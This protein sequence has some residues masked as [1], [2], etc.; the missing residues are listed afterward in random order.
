MTKGQFK[1]VLKLAF[2][3]FSVLLSGCEAEKKNAQQ[4]KIKVKRFSMKDV[5]MQTNFKLNNAVNEIKRF[6][7]NIN[8]GS[9]KL[10]FDDKSGLYFDDEKGLYIE[11]D[12]LKSYTFPIIRTSSDEK[13]KNICFN[14]KENGNYDVYLVKYDFTMQQ[15]LTL[16]EE[17]KAA[18][19]K[20]FISLMKDGVKLEE[21]KLQCIDIYVTTTTEYVVPVDEGE[22]TGNYGNT[23]VSHTTS[24]FIGSFCTMQGFSGGNQ[25]GGNASGESGG[26]GSSGTGQNPGTGTS[27]DIITGLNTE[28]IGNSL[29]DEEIFFYNYQ[30][31]TQMMNNDQKKIFESHPEFVNYLITNHWSASSMDLVNELISI[32]GNNPNNYQ[33]MEPFI[34]EKQI[35]GSDLDDCTKAILESLKNL[36]QNRIAEIITKLGNTNS[37]YSVKII[38]DNNLPSDTYGT[39]DWSTPTGSLVVPYNYTIKLNSQYIEHATK[40][41]I[42]STIIHELIHAYFLS[43]VDDLDYGETSNLNTFSILWDYYVN[44]FNGGVGDIAQHNQMAES[45]VNAMASALQEYQTG[46]QVSSSQQPQQIYKDLA[47]GGLGNT[48]PFNALTD[49][50]KDRII[51][52]NNAECHNTQQNANGNNYFPISRPCN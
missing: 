14:E 3:C 37:V 8:S 1:N 34:I 49:S 46:I 44:H 24:V 40:L 25:G 48:P 9:S 16:T 50:E 36:Q 41:S 4:S 13:I 7:T 51:A 22:L 27:D 19:E 12:N 33:S 42:A 6:N 29:N 28:T 18:S 26:S 32:I 39:T 45:Y 20:Q 52:V 43:L 47:W 11:K 2:I 23:T 5:A 35:D 17:Q 30:A 10:V 15:A 38:L 21:L 31:F